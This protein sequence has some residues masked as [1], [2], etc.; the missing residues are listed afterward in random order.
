MSTNDEDAPRRRLSDRVDRRA[1][2]RKMS[3]RDKLFVLLLGPKPVVDARSAYTAAGP[4]VKDARGAVDQPALF[5]S[6]SLEHV[7]GYMME[8]QQYVFP[9]QPM[10]VLA[11][12]ALWDRTFVNPEI[13]PAPLPVQPYFPG[14]LT[15][16]DS[17]STDHIDEY[18]V[19]AHMAQHGSTKVV[20]RTKAILQHIIS[21]FSGVPA[22]KWHMAHVRRYLLSKPVCL[23]FFRPAPGGVQ[24]AYHPVFGAEGP[25]SVSCSSLM[26]VDVHMYESITAAEPIWCAWTPKDKLLVCVA[27]STRLPELVASLVA[28]VNNDVPIIL[29]YTYALGPASF[30]HHQ[31]VVAHCRVD[32]LSAVAAAL[33]GSGLYPI[34]DATRGICVADERLVE[35]FASIEMEDARIADFDRTRMN[36]YTFAGTFVLYAPLYSTNKEEG[37]LYDCSRNLKEIGVSTGCADAI[38]EHGF[39]CDRNADNVVA[40]LMFSNYHQL[41]P[42]GSVPSEFVRGMLRVLHK[43]YT[44]KA[45][46]KGFRSWLQTEIT[47]PAA[48][49]RAPDDDASAKQTDAMSTVSTILRSSVPA[50]SAAPPAA[51]RSVVSVD[52]LRSFA[53]RMLT[54]RK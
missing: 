34:R 51:R 38:T 31:F 1:A 27:F 17:F 22:D 30:A 24:F 49:K 2:C 4:R 45:I 53:K 16:S 50:P 23:R 5:V 26:Q 40:H 47:P 21:V 14:Q 20:A 3:G 7:H 32:R 35:R 6:A 10:V 41:Y 33:Q 11:C 9:R 12:D 29:A 8:L 25:V 36:F 28:H 52:S 13:L 18:T 19:D 54:V 37:P 42:K 44:S 15:R 46:E 39:L 48:H 43:G